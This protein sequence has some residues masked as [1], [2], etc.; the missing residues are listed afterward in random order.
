MKSQFA[1]APAR[2]HAIII[3]TP[4]SARVVVVPLLLFLLLP[5]SLADLARSGWPELGHGHSS[6]VDRFVLL[7]LRLESIV[8]L[9]T[10]S[11]LL[12]VM[13]SRPTFGSEQ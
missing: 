5:L 6:L 7:E 11:S 1:S 2:V 13:E 10:K 12:N 9:N 3:V 4:H 8:R